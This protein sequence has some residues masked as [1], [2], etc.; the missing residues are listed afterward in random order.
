MHLEVHLSLGLGLGLGL[1][2]DCRCGIALANLSM[3]AKLETGTVKALLTLSVDDTD[4]QGKG[5]SDQRSVA[6]RHSASAGKRVLQGIVSSGVFSQAEKDH[7][8]ASVLANR[9]DLRALHDV[10]HGI[11]TKRQESQTTIQSH[12]QARQ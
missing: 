12:T 9:L 4:K 5:A 10:H 3:F 2:P 7:Q 1:N 8:E 11:D 6:I